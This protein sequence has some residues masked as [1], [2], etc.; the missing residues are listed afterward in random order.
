MTAYPDKLRSRV[1]TPVQHEFASY[2]LIAGH[3]VLDFLNTATARDQPVPIDW[4]FDYGSLLGWAR[5]TGRFGP[6]ELKALEVR[7]RHHPQ[8]AARA[9]RAVRALREHLHAM[10]SASIDGRPIERHDLAAFEQVWKRACAH[11]LLA[12]VDGELQVMHAIQRSK[13][14]LLLHTL[15]LDAAELLARAEQQRVRRCEGT[16]CGWLFIDTSKAGRRRWCDMATCGNVAKARRHR[17]Q[18]VSRPT[19]A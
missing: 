17:A 11:A 6:D 5:L 7:S 19:K 4:L 14:D 10:F 8:Q 2:D 15:V 12:T 9:L 3:T 18:R 13:L 1:M 16:H